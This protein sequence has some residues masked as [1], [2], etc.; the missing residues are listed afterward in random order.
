M[1]GLIKKDLLLIN[2]NLKIFLL[3]LLAYGLIA[4][5][6]NFDISYIIPFITVMLFIST[7]SYDD[8]NN[9]NCYAVTFPNGRKNVVKAKYITG[10]IITVISIMVTLFITTII[11]FLPGSSLNLSDV[12][13]NLTG[14]LAAVLILFSILCPLMFKYGTEKARILL[15]VAIFGFS[16]IIGICAEFIN[17]QAFSKFYK[18]AD[19]IWYIILP[20]FLI[21]ILLASYIWSKKIYQKKEF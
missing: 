3:I 20:I 18:I 19:G 11:S 1:L 9:W 21:S 4:L 7:F 12:I 5:N 16:A 17:F 10:I 2:K 8:F 13:A 6:G 14:V 15:F